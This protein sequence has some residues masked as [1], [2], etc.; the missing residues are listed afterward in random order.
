MR[1]RRASTR[2]I[3][4]LLA[5]SA[6][7]ATAMVVGAA[8]AFAAVPNAPTIGTAN[9]G[10]GTG[11][12][13]VAFTPA[14]T[15]SA[16]TSF[17]ATAYIG[18]TATT[19]TAT[20][21]T[22][23]CIVSGLTVGQ[24]YKFAV[25]ATNG[26]GNSAS[27]A[28]SNS[29][30]A[31]LGQNITFVNPGNQPFGTSP[32]LTATSDGT[33]GQPIVFSSSTPA[34]CTVTTGGQLTFVTTGTCIINADQAGT[35]T[36]LPAPRVT[37]TFTVTPA[38]TAITVTSSPAT[39]VVG[40]PVTFTA[41]LS[42]VPPGQLQWAVN[43]V[44]VGSSVTLTSGVATYTFTPTTPLP[45]GSQIVA[46]NYLGDANHAAASGQV[47]QTVAKAATTTAVQ[48]TGDTL[49][50]S[51]AVVA[52]GAG[53]PTGTVSFVVS[54]VTVGSAPLGSNGLA[55]FTS[56]GVGNHGVTATYSGD[57][58]F[59]TSSGNR[60]PINP[61]VVT[62]VTSNTPKT[63][64]GWYRSPVSVSFTCTANTAPL[65]SGCPATQTLSRNAGQ[66]SVVE[67]VT[68]TDGGSTTVSVTGINIDRI[69]PRLTVRRHGITLSCRGVD[70]LSG[71]ASCVIHRHTH[72]RNGVRT[73]RWTAVARDRAGNVTIKR[74]RF[75]Y[76]V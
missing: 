29:V 56:T 36:V 35:A 11:Q 58:S 33:S 20:C 76:L 43:G 45:A 38:T 9:A 55:T 37:Q 19:L 62:H 3:G 49:S 53:T 27:S 50:A 41:T 21:T 12:V 63:R 7:I 1:V 46:A 31:E 54:G 8:P 32:A 34:V 25:V 2:Q 67:T 23:P 39:S 13:I 65:V 5:A 70:G 28:K 61:T 4:G 26:S 75:G 22:S 24:A 16:A 15:G 14:T 73:V 69:A 71:I 44:N 60:A 64:F 47:T 66:Q 52:P 74:G 68:A 42:P 10:P 6:V 30:T 40:Q 57:S 17:T 72:T 48:V 51:V 59:L 18:T